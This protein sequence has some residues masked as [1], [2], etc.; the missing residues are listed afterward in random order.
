MHR[1][2]NATAAATLPTADSAGTPGYWTKGN[3]GTGTP[4]TVM[5]QDWFNAVQ[6]EFIA[7]LMAAGVTPTKGDYDQLLTS[8]NTMYRAGRLLNVQVFTANGTY[9]PTAGMASAIMEV[10]GGGGAG[11]GAGGATGGNVSLGAPGASGGYARGRFL[12]A[13]IGASQAVTVGAGG[14]AVSGG[15][16]GNGG[17]SSVGSLISAPGGPGGGTL[18]DQAPP[19]QNGN[20]TNSSAP[21]G[22]NIVGS[23]G[24][25]QVA[26]TAVSAAT[27]A[28]APGGMSV[29]G[30]GGYGV[31]VNAPGIS[32]SNP[33]AGGGA[34]SVNA[35]GGTIAGGNGF[36]GIVII[37]EYS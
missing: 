37:W 23:V 17:T 27:V 26:T 31:G 1:I 9:T 12:A 11:G 28:S 18:T 36:R 15:A 5:D 3:P 25:G 7:V 20:G 6:E 13:A 30:P 16:G 21:A 24:A 14:V 29:F 32:A 4:A 10:Q 33:G 35:S 2:D 22:A 8:L 19:T 34:A